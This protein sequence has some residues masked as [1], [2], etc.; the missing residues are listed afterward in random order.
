MYKDEQRLTDVVQRCGG[1]LSIRGA[2]HGRA[3]VHSNK[4]KARLAEK[5]MLSFSKKCQMMPAEQAIILS[6][7]CVNSC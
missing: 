7:I 5:V 2:I 1:S 4:P 6:L 3:Y